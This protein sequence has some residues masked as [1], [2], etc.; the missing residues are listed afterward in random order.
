[1]KIKCSENCVVY[2]MS[3]NALPCIISVNKK[4]VYFA[5]RAENKVLWTRNR[6]LSSRSEQIKV[7]QTPFARGSSAF[8]ILQE[9]EAPTRLRFKI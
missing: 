7:L 9:F 6:V 8:C 4:T 5:P 3:F 1:M 2:Q